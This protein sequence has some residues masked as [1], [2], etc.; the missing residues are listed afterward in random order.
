METLRERGHK[1]TA[2]KRAYRLRLLKAAAALAVFGALLPGTANARSNAVG[3]VYYK[4]EAACAQPAGP[5]DATCL[6]M[7]RVEV[8]AGT[9]GARPFQIVAHSYATGPAGGLTPGDLASAYSFNPTATG[10]GRTVAIVD[11]YNDPNIN[12]DLQTFDSNYGLPACSIADGCL[13]VVS[14]TGSTTSL[15]ANDTIGWSIEESL[16]VESVHSVCQECNIILVEANSQSLADLGA[17]ENEAVSLG[18]SIVTNSWGLAETSGDSAYESDFNHPGVVLTAA[19]GDQGY[20]DWDQLIHTNAPNFPAS[21]G[22]VVAVGGTS[23]VL[24]SNGTRSSETVWNND[25][26]AGGDTMDGASG[27]GCSTLFPAPSWQTS[28]SDWSSTACGSSRLAADISADGN[29]DTGFDIYDSYNCGTDCQN[30]DG[31][32]YDWATFGGTSLASTI[33]A[34]IWAL[35]GGAHGVNY[36]ASTLYSYLGTSSLYDVT[37]G[38]DGACVGE[39]ASPCLSSFAAAAEGNPNTLGV[40]I[41]DCSWNASGVQSAGDLACDAATGYDGPSGVGT[42]NGLTAFAPS[43]TPPSVSGVSPDRAPVGGN[44]VVTVTGSGFSTVSGATTFAFGSVAGGSVS[45]VSS[46]TCTVV[47]PPGAPGS[48]ELSATVA[49]LS[50]S[51]FGFSYYAPGLLRV[52]TSPAVASQISVDGVVADTWGLNWAEEPPG[53][54][55]VCFAAVAGYGTPGCQTVTVTSGETTAVT[56][57]F[58]QHGYLQVET[59]PAV[60]GEVTV[61][62]QGSSTVV[63]NDDWGVY[64][65]LPAGS[66]QVCFG[67]VAGYAPPSCASATVSAGSTR[68]VVGDYTVSVGASGQSGVGLLRVTTSPAVASQITVDGAVADTW[69]LNWLEIAPGSHTVC[70]SAIQGY[71]TPACQMVSVTAG[72]TTSVTGTFVQRGFLQVVTSPAVAGTVFVNGVPADDWGL[73]TD[74]PAGTYTLCFGAVAGYTAPACQSA[75]VTAGSTTQVTAPY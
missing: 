45:C 9:A 1:L 59:S 65:D 13:T 35:A 66:Y 5:L 7:R 3:S 14:Q 16:D 29:P 28:L 62:P 70:F 63:A 50:S 27:G 68:V 12:S 46:T 49:S 17:S 48:A 19:T 33:I 22:D 21:Y 73:Y 6:A 52:T 4:T 71:T 72:Q 10:S 2:R 15:P 8:P 34:G 51:G 61:T 32:P 55:T 75:T 20:Y 25:G 42:P 58:S 39:A 47:V 18:A 67:A 60:P 31:Q 37:T 23:L 38:G 36:P 41:L 40:G 56:G 30:T 26:P 24:N 44:V 43:G 57:T 74:L 11:A 64:T 54:H 53:S 69:G